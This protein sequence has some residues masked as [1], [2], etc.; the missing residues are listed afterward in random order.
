MRGYKFGI[1]R[2]CQV[3]A[4]DKV[5]LWDWWDRDILGGPLHSQGVLIRS[6][7]GHIAGRLAK[8][9]HALV[10]LYTVVETRGHA[11]DG[12]MRRGHEAWFGPCWLVGGRVAERR[13]D[14]AIYLTDFEAN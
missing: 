10:A 5:L 12:Q 1:H 7:N 6:K 14:V 3:H 8:R 11:M 13:F 4:L 2:H 9:F